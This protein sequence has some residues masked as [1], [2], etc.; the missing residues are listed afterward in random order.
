M[1]GSFTQI[2][3]G[4][5]ALTRTRNRLAAVDVQRAAAGGHYK[6]TMTFRNQVQGFFVQLPKML[7]AFPFKNGAYTALFA[8]FDLVMVGIGVAAGQVEEEG[9]LHHLGLDAR[10]G[11][12]KVGQRLRQQVLFYRNKAAYNSDMASRYHAAEKRLENVFYLIES[13]QKSLDKTANDDEDNIDGFDKKSRIEDAIAKLVLRDLMERQEEE[14]QQGGAHQ[15]VS[16]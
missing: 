3:T 14:E 15:C 6:S 13:L 10:V 7:L 8:F 2:N 11:S 16:A 5:A 4:L 9:V 1:G 12:R